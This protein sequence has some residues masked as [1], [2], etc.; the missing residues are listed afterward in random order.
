M[1]SEHASAQDVPT[2]A[3]GSRGRRGP[4]SRFR[5]VAASWMRGRSTREP[6]RGSSFL[7]LILGYSI[8]GY[9]RRAWPG[10]KSERD[11]NLCRVRRAAAAKRGGT[12]PARRPAPR[13]LPRAPWRLEGAGVRGVRE[14][15]AGGRGG[16]G[17]TR[18]GTARDAWS[19]SGP[20]PART[21]RR[22]AQRLGA[23]PGA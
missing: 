11:Y 2:A 13:W 18:C 5:R 3:S 10:I 20:A 21:F 4:S 8:S 1:G 22:A 16:W 12:A 7:I 14:P 17:A 9:G 6:W 19:P 15:V 23:P